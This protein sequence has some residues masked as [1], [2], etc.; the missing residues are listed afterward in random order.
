M[1]ELSL[2]FESRYFPLKK[3][4]DIYRRSIES[5]EEFWAEQARQ[6]DWFKTWDRVLDWDP[7]FARWFAGGILNASY[8]CAD[9]HVKSWRR[10]KVAIYWEGEN[11]ESRGFSYSTLFSEV[12]RFAALLKRLGV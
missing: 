1:H 5:P 12:N 8:L 7:P 3:F 9:R 2:P 11:G 4:L 6:L 10:S